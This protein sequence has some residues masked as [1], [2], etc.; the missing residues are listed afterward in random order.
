MV[1]L[2]LY[3]DP[4]PLDLAW[5]DPDENLSRMDDAIKARLSSAPDIAPEARLFVFP[6]VTL[7]AFVTE[8]PK[9]FSIDPPD[10]Y[11]KRLCALASEHG[12]GIAAGFPEKNP[13]DE[14]RPFNVLVLIAPDGRIVAR[15]RKM[16]LFT[17]GETPETDRYAAGGAGTICLYRGWNIALSICFDVRFTR[18]YHEY[19]KMGVDLVLVSSCWVGGPHKT[20]QYKTINS[21]HAVLTQAY[22]A[23]VNRAGKDPNFEFDG[24]AYV[25]SPFGENIYEEGPVEL[26]AKTLEECRSLVVRPSDRASYPVNFNS[27]EG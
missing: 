7:T 2:P 13:D 1:R 12:T 20:Y 18:L 15:Y 27:S 16:H 25:F 10:E 5:N 24:S 21:A 17:F 4:V 3:V 11:V 22:V 26:N 8:S 6:E 19:A 14:A 23:A 9:S